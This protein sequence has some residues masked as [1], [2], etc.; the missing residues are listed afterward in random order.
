MPLAERF[1]RK[2]E[3]RRA[4][5]SR[6]RLVQLRGDQVLGVQLKDLGDPSKGAPPDGIP[7][8]DVVDR[9]KG[10]ASTAR[11]GLLGETLRLASG[12]HLFG[13]RK[14]HKRS[15]YQRGSISPR[16]FARFFRVIT[17]MLTTPGCHLP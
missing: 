13:E 4:R 12:A 2:A 8:L 11:Q 7:A 15:F 16:L 1:Q 17:E 6:G 3:A 5:C 9:P 14:S 10:K